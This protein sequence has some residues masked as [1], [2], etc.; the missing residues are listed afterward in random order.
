[1]DGSGIRGGAAPLPGRRTEFERRSWS[2]FI[3]H[4]SD[5][6]GVIRSYVLAPSILTSVNALIFRLFG[7]L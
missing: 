3:A 5:T 2:P 6:D 1:M 4:L 7:T